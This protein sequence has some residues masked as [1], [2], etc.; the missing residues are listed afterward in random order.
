MFLCVVKKSF[1]LNRIPCH[2]TK[3]SAETLL[4]YSLSLARKGLTNWKQEMTFLTNQLNTEEQG[5]LTSINK[6]D[7]NQK[8][9][10]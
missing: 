8:G 4:L 6:L 7:W 1:L 9:S 2:N 10:N 3:F 5:K